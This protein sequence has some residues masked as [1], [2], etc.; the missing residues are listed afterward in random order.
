MVGQRCQSTWCQMVEL[1]GRSR[2]CR[3]AARAGGCAGRCDRRALLGL[4]EGHAKDQLGHSL[5]F[6]PERKTRA[7]HKPFSRKPHVPNESSVH[8]AKRP[9]ATISN[10]RAVRNPASPR[11]WGSASSLRVRWPAPPT[12]LASRNDC[13]MAA[14]S[15]AASSPN[16]SNPSPGSF[17]PGAFSAV[18]HAP[19]AG[20]GPGGRPP[21]SPHLGKAPQRPVRRVSPT[22]GERESGGDH[23]RAGTPGDTSP[24][25]ANSRT[26]AP[27]SAV[28]AR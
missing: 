26:A 25:A 19:S 12:S 10:H 8:T 9:G 18:W 17:R 11:G 1:S 21:P 3:G 15:A 23:T 2:R 24:G 6:G 5:Q 13:S 22:D 27:R 7:F 14:R 28:S 20:A 4:E 16:Y